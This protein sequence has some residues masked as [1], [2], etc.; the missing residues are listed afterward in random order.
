MIKLL[1]LLPKRKK[2]FDDNLITVVLA[3]FAFAI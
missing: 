3:I 2:G 1:F